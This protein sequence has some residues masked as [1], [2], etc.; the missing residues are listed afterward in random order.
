MDI[1]KVKEV[2]EKLV[3]SSGE[4]ESTVKNLNNNVKDA[5]GKEW[6]GNAATDFEKEY[7]EFYRQVKKQ[8]E[9]MDDLS[10]RMRLEIVEWEMMNKELH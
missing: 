7:E 3:L 2:W 1:D 5:V 9:T 10:E 6:V 8:T 4:I